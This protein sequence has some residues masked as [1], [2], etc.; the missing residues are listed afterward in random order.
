MSFSLFVKIYYEFL[1]TF[2]GE[3]GQSKKLDTDEK[4]GN[5]MQ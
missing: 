4:L 5:D 3:I 1:F 2:I